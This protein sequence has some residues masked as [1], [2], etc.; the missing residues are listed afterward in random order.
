MHLLCT[1]G[2]VAVPCIGVF[3]SERHSAVLSGSMISAPQTRVV[4]DSVN[5]TDS[6]S[7]QRSI[8]RAEGLG[9]D[10]AKALM[11]Q[12]CNQMYCQLED[13]NTITIGTAGA[14]HIE[15]STGEIVF[16]Q[17]SAE[18]W[19]PTFDIKPLDV[20]SEVSEKDIDLVSE[21][22][23][24]RREALMQSVRRTASSAAAIAVF[25]LLTFIVAQLPTRQHTQ[26]SMAG[27][28]MNT[29]VTDYDEPLIAQPGASSNALVLILN[30][31]ADA[32]SEVEVPEVKAADE[33]GAYCLVVAS[34]AS[35][36][37]ANAFIAAHST[38]AISLSLLAENG[39][40]RV[41][42]AS[43]DSFDSVAAQGRQAGIFEAYPSA[44]VCRR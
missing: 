22:L 36:K 29:V 12:S 32:V 15:A 33:P 7:L 24:S 21:A 43:G 8:E 30:T 25:A 4:F 9:A 44:W 39:R 1:D 17:T 23:K 35:E 28:G 13:G 26:P 27:V 38:D 6:V 31:P 2:I 5:V 18:S 11:M 20:K 19:L 37:E 42:A 3:R 34:L 14:L 40:Y 41:Y 10:E 16:E